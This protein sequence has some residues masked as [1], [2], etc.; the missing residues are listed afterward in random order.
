[1]IASIFLVALLRVASAASSEDSFIYNGK[2]FDVA[3]VWNYCLR[4]SKEFSVDK[5]VSDYGAL[6]STTLRRLKADGGGAVRLRDG[7][8]PVTS[9][10]IIQD[11]TCLL[12][13][14]VDG[15]VLRV[16][17]KATS[18]SPTRG[19]VSGDGVKNAVLRDF[20]VDANK[21]EQKDTKSDGHLSKFGIFLANV[22]YLWIM[23]VRVRGAIAY[24]ST[25]PIP[26]SACD[27]GGL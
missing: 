13:D 12:G 25:F 23:N 6:L 9:S 10:I 1:M 7:V 11:R 21:N 2:S 14:S 17:N 8:Y 20:T 3:P 22:K 4:D 16:M 27:T 26:A 5:N 15:A 18:S 24:G 19:V